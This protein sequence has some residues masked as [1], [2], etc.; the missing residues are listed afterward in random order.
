MTDSTQVPLL[1]RMTRLRHDAMAENPLTSSRAL[2]LVL[3]KAASDTVGLVLTV[4]GVSEDV[5]KLDDLLTGL[6]NDLLLVGLMRD[7]RLVGVAAIDMQL[8]A[9]I[10]EM[11]IIRALI[12]KPADDRM[13]TG[14]DKVMCDPMLSTFLA[15]LPEALLGT[16]LDGWVDDVLVGDRLESCRL[17]G[18]VLDDCHYTDMQMS[19]GLGITDRQGL[20]QIA[21]PVPNRPAQPHDKDPVS[22]DWDSALQDTVAEAPASLDALL[23]EFTIPLAQANALAVGTVLP[24]P[25][26][27]VNSV[28]LMAPDGY[29]VAQAK[30]GQVGGMRA[31]RLQSV[32]LPEMAELGPGAAA[33]AME[34]SAFGMDAPMEM[35][36]P[37]ADDFPMMVAEGLPEIEGL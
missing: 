19:V 9:A 14:T 15:A 33:M 4:Q 6:S 5:R 32:P 25:G 10:L 22:V 3:S 23:H 17:A 11:Q 27:T 31:V 2:R 1:R 21:L 36:N 30:L 34:G 8:R 12:D 13:P 18:L 37:M 16:D 28:R 7:A 24:L 35:D 29:E 20:L 26:C